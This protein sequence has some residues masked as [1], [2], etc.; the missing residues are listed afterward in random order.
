[1][2]LKDSQ[3]AHTFGNKL[4]FHTLVSVNPLVLL[5]WKHKPNK[6]KGTNYRN[7]EQSFHFFVQVMQK[8]YYHHHR[9]EVKM[10]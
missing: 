5:Y 8:L 2:D 6:I 3:K 4:C 7:L 9:V 10:V 1:M